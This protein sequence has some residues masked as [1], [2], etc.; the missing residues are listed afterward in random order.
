MSVIHIIVHG[1]IALVPATDASGAANHMTALLVNAQSQPSEASG[2]PGFKECFVPHQPGIAVTTSSNAECLAAGCIPEGEH[3]C[4]CSLVRK[5]V[6]LQAPIPAE[7]EK[8][9]INSQPANGLPFDFKEARDF[10]Y[11][12]NLSRLGYELDQEE[13]IDKPIPSPALIARMSFPFK[14]VSACSLGT[15]RD[16]GGNNVHPL[17]FRPIE[18]TEQAGE[19]SQALSQMVLAQ[20]DVQEGPVTLV[21]TDFGG[22]NQRTLTLHP[23]AGSYRIEL[24]NMRTSEEGAHDLPP[25]HF[26]DGG[27]E[28]DFAFFYN[29]VKNAPP[30]RERPIPHIKFT[31]WKSAKDIETAECNFTDDHFPNSHPICGLASFVP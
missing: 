27:V 3:D 9:R 21:I 20:L 26:C 13:F 23:I 5:E 2:L 12:A 15:R 1:L 18:T 22:G 30:W 19:P 29:L 14:S 24:F 31:R 28:R 10:S 7:M 4:H 25:D 8:Q 11:V 16:E 6:S 17:S